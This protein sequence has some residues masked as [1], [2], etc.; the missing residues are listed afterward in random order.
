MNRTISRLFTAIACLSASPLFSATVK[1]DFRSGFTNFAKP[2]SASVKIAD[3]ILSNDTP[4]SGYTALNADGIGD[5]RLSFELKLAD[6]KL[7]ENGQFSIEAERGYGVWRLYFIRYGKTSKITSKFF[8]KGRDKAIFDETFDLDM[9]FDSWMKIGL[10]ASRTI[11]KLKVNGREYVLGT[12][13]GSGKITFGS[14]RQP[15]AMRDFSI[16]YKAPE[17]ILPNRLPNSSFEFASNAD[18]PDYWRGFGERY[19]TLGFPGEFSTAEGRQEFL[20]KFQLDSKE[21]CHGRNSLRIQAPF[22]LM[23][24]LA[25]P[26]PGNTSLVLSCYVKSDR[27][28]AEIRLGVTGDS[29]KKPLLSE[30][31]K[32]GQKWQRIELPLGSVKEKISVFAQPQGEAVFWLDAFQLEEGKQATEYA[33][34]W[35]DDGFA[36]PYD[37]NKFQCAENVNAIRSRFSPQVLV[38]GSAPEIAETALIPSD[39]SKDRFDLKVR[40]ANHAETPVSGILTGVI[41]GKSEAEQLKTAGFALKPGENGEVLLKD[42]RIAD[43]KVALQLSAAD[44]S[45]K[46]LGQVRTMADAPPTMRLYP[47]YSSYST[48]KEARVVVEF[49]PSLLPKLK[50]GKIEI[51]ALVAGYPAYAWTKNVFP[52]DAPESRQIFTIPLKK[53]AGEKWFTLTGTLYGADNK[54][55]CRKNAE[56]LTRDATVPDVRINRI[57]RG[58]Y[59]DGNPFFPRGI[60]C[61]NFRE[62]QLEYYK[63]CGFEDLQYVSHWLKSGESVEFAALCGRMGLK[64]VA[65]HVSRPFALSP[66]E[67]MKRLRDTPALVGM[68]PNDESADP[69]VRQEAAT[70]NRAA[71]ERLVWVNHHF[72]SYRAFAERLEEMPGDVLSIDRYPFIRQPPCRPQNTMDIYSIEQCLEM[73]DRDGRRE[74]KPVF[75]WLQGAE[76]FAKEP[77]PEQLTFQVYIALVNHAMGF[78]YFGGIPQSET[79]W[80]KMIELNREIQA[81]VP[82]L[83]SLEPEPE[84]VCDNKEIRLLAKKTGGRITVIAINRS[85]EKVRAGIKLPGLSAKDGIEVKF[86]NR[87]IAPDA[88]GSWSDEFAPLSRHVYEFSM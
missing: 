84:A 37:V 50:G 59:V 46:T 65:F 66:A 73:M 47:E 34:C 38:S 26:P 14:Y 1:D 76:G 60:Q 17:K 43:P 51:T 21:A 25:D 22:H 82:A 81:L 33:P 77:T 36:L 13:P 49:A 78:A 87:R 35:L 67:M 55:L 45:G 74:R 72:I 42:F 9:P 4:Y 11:F 16:D 23:N 32:V 52:L 79:V 53:Q 39:P 40:L 27:E 6:R 5:F 2:S 48:E 29:L 19:R 31:F 57:N 88:G 20:R 41:S 62:K 80:R 28:N 61:L 63:A 10:E 15:F 69:I 85:L 56:L 18:V 75:L 3:G 70:V 68:I 86:E 24:P 8:E 30:L 58:V 83:F 71:P 12:A 64:T 7:K 44:G 54:V